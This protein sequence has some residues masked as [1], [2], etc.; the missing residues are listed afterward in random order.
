MAERVVAGE[1]T[2]A[3]EF[4]EGL[5]EMH[6][7]ED[8]RWLLSLWL[9]LLAA[10]SREEGLRARAA[11]FWRRNFD[12]YVEALEAGAKSR[13]AALA[14]DA[15]TLAT[16]AIAL[17]VGLSVQRYVDPERVNLDVWPEAFEALFAGVEKPHG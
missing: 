9:E 15:E 2:S 7:D 5:R 3:R 1:I 14:F 12:A 6:A 17:D 11:D 13:G 10:A 16:A 8:A 4:G